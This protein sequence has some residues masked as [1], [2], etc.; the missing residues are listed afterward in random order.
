LFWILCEL[1]ALRDELALDFAECD[2]LIL[3]RVAKLEIGCPIHAGIEEDRVTV[4]QARANDVGAA[5]R[6]HEK[7]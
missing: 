6:K 4:H 5:S 2:V 7:E 1:V 3:R